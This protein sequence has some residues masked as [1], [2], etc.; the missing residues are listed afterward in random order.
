MQEKWNEEVIIISLQCPSL[1]SDE[2][3]DLKM[4]H[5]KIFIQNPFQ[6]LT[7]KILSKTIV[8]HTIAAKVREWS[9]Q[10]L[11]AWPLQSQVQSSK[12][13]GNAIHYQSCT[14]I[15]WFD[16]TVIVGDAA[17]QKIRH[18]AQSQLNRTQ[19]LFTFLFSGKINWQD[20]NLFDP[21]LYRERICRAILSALFIKLASYPRAF[22]HFH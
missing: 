7:H 8:K 20:G 21:S 4:V 11:R 1:V 16:D 2:K 18:D 17:S 15:H 12:L 14:L 3:N 9:S 13:I 22:C 10:V 6:A 5:N 19:N